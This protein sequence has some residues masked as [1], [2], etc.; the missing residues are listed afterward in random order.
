MDKL[1]LW[2]VIVTIF[3]QSS[4]A[5]LAPFFP[6]VAEKKGCSSFIVGLIICSYSI[7]YIATSY[8]VG[9]TLNWFGRRR[10]CVLGLIICCVSMAGF[11][12]MNWIEN[13]GLFIAL[14]L[15]WRLLA[16]VGSSFIHVS[17]YAM[18]AIKWPDEVQQKI[19]LLEAASGSGLFIGPVVGSVIY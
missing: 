9:R 19:A 8:I 16:G 17:V 13:K 6:S 2:L 5:L 1:L 10:Y 14:S 18:A 11:G 4:F 3:S 15:F 12:I 7:S